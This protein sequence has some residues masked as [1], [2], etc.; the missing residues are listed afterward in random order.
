MKKTPIT[1]HSLFVTVLAIMAAFDGLM[2][3]QSAEP[4]AKEKFA[5][6][7]LPAAKITVL[8]DNIV[9]A[10]QVLGEWGVSFFIE[11]DQ[12]HILF[13]TGRGRVIMENAK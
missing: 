4:A 1:Y 13:D 12:H 5:L 6:K 8:V 7:V 2:P 10:D 9:G 11:T 3:A